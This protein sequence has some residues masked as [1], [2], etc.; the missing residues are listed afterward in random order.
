MPAVQDTRRRRASPPLYE[1]TGSPRPALYGPESIRAFAIGN[2]S[3]AFGE[4]YRVFDSERVIARLPGPPYQFLD[5]IVAI[6]DAEP[7]KMVPGGVIEAEYDVPGDAWYFAADRQPTMP[8]AVL[9]EV[10]LQPCG[11]LAAY[12]GSALTSP[13]DLSFRN[14][15]GNATLHRVVG[16]D[17]GTLTTR[18]KITQVSTSGG[19]II[20]G[21][22]F[23]VRA[24]D[25]PIYDGT[26]TFGFFTK[27]ALA[28]QVGLRDVS[29]VQP[30][31]SGREFA[32]P[33]GAPFPDERWRMID[34]IER[35]GEDLWRGRKRIDP[36]AWFFRAHF[37]QDP[38]WP[39][40]LGLEAMLQLL[41]LA[42][43]ERWGLS[44]RGIFHTMLGRH[45]WIYRGQVLPTDRDVLVQAEIA[46]WE[47]SPRRLVANGY[48]TV[49]GRL[50]YRMT[51][52][53]LSVLER[54]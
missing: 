17:V 36:D 24:G 22:T 25:V 51:D 1:V 18:V 23:A 12:V 42:A 49:D 41:K 44:E 47:D 9:L 3:E 52:F 34:S 15:G 35:H 28:Q 13:V 46:R 8:F 6:D 54:P 48:L 4:P 20:Q 50:I 32:Y 5:R 16:P 14:L 26:T 30:A 40:S 10:A 31:G 2:P 11:W 29:P 21:F 38:V 7:W 43:R 33:E 53:A 45:Q 19:M 37:H 27:A 39:G